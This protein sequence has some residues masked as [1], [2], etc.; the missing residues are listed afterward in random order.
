TDGKKH[1]QDHRYAE[2]ASALRRG[3][4]LAE[5][6]P[7]SGELHDELTGRLHQAEQAQLAAE[8]HAFLDRVR[9]LYGLDSVPPEQL[10][11]LATGWQVFWDQH[12]A[13]HQ[14][15]GSEEVEPELARS[16]RTDLLDL[17]ILGSDLRVR[18]ASVGDTA[19]AREEALRV[20]GEA[21]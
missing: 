9:L 21:E 13:I 10:R 14:R 6:L 8:L 17:A 18:S 20:L 15:L 11:P 19:V 3:L 16:V 1:L 2:A 4:S 7:G 5:G 12:Q